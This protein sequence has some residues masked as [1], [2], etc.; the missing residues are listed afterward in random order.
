MNR[1]L[2]VGLFTLAGLA[3]FTAGLFMIGNRHEAFERHLVLYSEFSELS[4]IAKGSKVRVAGMDAGRVLQID[5]PNSVSSKFRVEIQIDDRL[6]PI[7]RRNS[8]V[9]IDTEG[10]VGNTYLS[11]SP[12]SAAAPA[13]SS[14][15]TLPSK[16]AIELSALLDK[17]TETINDF[18]S[19]LHYMN[20][21]LVTL[22]DGLNSTLA[23]ARGTLAN[24]NDVVLDLK[25]GK[26]TAGM[27]LT[28]ADIAN[29]IR[30]TVG[31]TEQATAN[32]QMTSQRADSLVADFQSK[33]FPRKMDQTL[34]TANETLSRLD[35]TAGQV[36]HVVS[37]V[38]EPDERG[39]SAGVNLRET[40]STANAVTG[41]LADLSEALKHNFLLR[42]FFRRR[43]FYNLTDLSPTQYRDDREFTDT[44][45][46][47]LWISAEQ[48][49][50]K[51]GSGGEELSQQGKILL[52]QMLSQF[53]DS[54]L[55]DP[56]V[57][58]G[59]AS[60]GS[61]SQNVDRS[62]ERAVAVRNYICEHFHLAT[63]G[64]GAVALDDRPPHATG[65][66]TWDGIS[67]VHLRNGKD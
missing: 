62:R 31:H 42:G 10:I 39:V 41:N 30:R 45:N 5:L 16:E 20:G 53:G 23:D 15:D 49:F 58:E 1:N 57:V 47:R 33:E 46:Q 3:L 64:V 63:L 27:L 9:S 50:L 67:I 60:G 29:E 43:G 36:E 61:I 25:N 51:N 56:M 6:H 17:A 12:G 59:Y 52:D 35:A 40:I 34:S 22:S 8:V 14:G 48:I 26:G 7:I 18:D 65:R 28:D 11:I 13:V 21:Q 38:A 24:V 44:K 19:T 37:D 55:D 32:L 66:T 2:T 4:G 54:M